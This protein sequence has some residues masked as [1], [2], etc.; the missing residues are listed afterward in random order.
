MPQYALNHINCFEVMKK[1]KWFILYVTQSEDINLFKSSGY[2]SFRPIRAKLRDTWKESQFVKN[3]WN[4]IET[5][6]KS[7]KL[8]H[9]KLHRSRKN[10]MEAH[11]F[12]KA[13][14]IVTTIFFSSW[15][16]STKNRLNALPNTA[17]WFVYI[18]HTFFWLCVCFI[19]SSLWI[20]FCYWNRL[21][22]LKN[23]RK[24]K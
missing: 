17:I 2:Q 7:R 14:E 3:D 5:R 13:I 9:I 6:F 19:M 12:G 4:P 16:Q 8:L 11:E 23:I 15:N 22:E 1:E 21:H 10:V 20:Y 18:F 24:T